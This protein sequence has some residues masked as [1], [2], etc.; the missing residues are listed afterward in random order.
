MSKI[1]PD[2]LGIGKNILSAH[3]TVPGWWKTEQYHTMR[4]N[5]SHACLLR[6]LQEDLA[7]GE[8]VPDEVFKDF[9]ELPKPLSWFTARIGRVVHRFD[10]HGHIHHVRIDDES[11]ATQLYRAEQ[12][13]LARYQSNTLI[14]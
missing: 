2:I 13:G 11:T 6:S 7:K 8:Q 1:R 12:E 3:M 10:H 9:P 4:F 14:A 5:W